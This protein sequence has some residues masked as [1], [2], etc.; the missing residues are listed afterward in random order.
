MLSPYKISAFIVASLTLALTK[1][2]RNLNNLY[3]SS[4]NCVYKLRV[5]S[6]IL[7]YK[8]TFLRNFFLY[9]LKFANHKVSKF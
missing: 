7:F 3:Y 4:N 1:L 5:H 2:A 6:I 8:F 9:K